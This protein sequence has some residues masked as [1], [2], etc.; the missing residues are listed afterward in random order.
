M[1]SL[2]DK[3]ASESLV[4]G[5]DFSKEWS[6]LVADAARVL[7]HYEYRPLENSLVVISVSIFDE[8]LRAMKRC[9]RRRCHFNEPIN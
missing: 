2:D 3:R 1:F 8:F 5:D 7:D 4:T 6:E 9:A